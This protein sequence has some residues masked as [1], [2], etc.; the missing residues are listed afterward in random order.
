MMDMFYIKKDLMYTIH[1]QLDIYFYNIQEVQQSSFCIAALS[2]ATC[3]WRAAELLLSLIPATDTT[4]SCSALFCSRICT[5][6]SQGA[7]VCISF[8]NWA[9]QLPQLNESRPS[10]GFTSI[11]NGEGPTAVWRDG[12]L[13]CANLCCSLFLWHFMNNKQL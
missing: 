12:A 2:H 7:N 6:R 5:K 8:W 9:Q 4:K 3:L 10:L 11:W 13:T 1:Y